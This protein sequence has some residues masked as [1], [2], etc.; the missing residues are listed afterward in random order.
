MEKHE[1][2]TEKGG[3]KKKEKKKGTVDEKRLETRGDE[4]AILIE[5]CNFRRGKG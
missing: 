1:V 3:K 4:G 2:P 5:K